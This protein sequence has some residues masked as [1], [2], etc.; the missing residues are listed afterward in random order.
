MTS[1]ASSVEYN[2][3]PMTGPAATT[4]SV[5]EISAAASALNHDVLKQDTGSFNNRLMDSLVASM[6]GVGRNV[7]IYI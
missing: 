5:R 7:N 4:A 6:T 3:Y 2:K 1:I